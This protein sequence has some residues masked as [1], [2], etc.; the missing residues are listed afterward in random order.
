MQ[1]QRL[2]LPHLGRALLD[3]GFSAT[4][5]STHN[6]ACK[7]LP[8]V[9]APLGLLTQVVIAVARSRAGRAGNAQHS[10]LYKGLWARR[11]NLAPELDPPRIFNW[12]AL[13]KQFGELGVL[14]GKGQAP[15]RSSSVK[16]RPRYAE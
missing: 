1:Y 2:G 5:T 14:D 10:P 6:I 12:A 15:R 16:P 4:P 3:P 11:G 13:A 8:Y 9:F 7:P